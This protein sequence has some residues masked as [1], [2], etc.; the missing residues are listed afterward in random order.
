MAT[1]QNRL[2]RIEKQV[3]RV[4]ARQDDSVLVR[5]GVWYDDEDGKIIPGS[6]PVR[7][8]P[9]AAAGQ[10]GIMLAPEPCDTTEQFEVY[11][12]S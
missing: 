6:G 8:V 2:S 12:I 1:L 7:R 5:Y 10:C 4:K 9:V 3:A 11:S